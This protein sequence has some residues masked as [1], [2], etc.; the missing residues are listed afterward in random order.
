MYGL[1]LCKRSWD[2][3]ERHLERHMRGLE[4]LYVIL[5]T[6]EGPPSGFLFDTTALRRLVAEKFRVG[7]L[8]A[9]LNFLAPADSMISF[10]VTRDMMWFYAWGHDTIWDIS[11]VTWT[12]PEFCEA[13]KRGRERSWTR[14]TCALR[15]R[16]Y[17]YA[18]ECRDMVTSLIPQC[19]CSISLCLTPKVSTSSARKC[20][21]KFRATV[22]CHNHRGSSVN[23]NAHAYSQF[24]RTKFNYIIS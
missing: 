6:C 1:R 10:K 14:L 11:Y 13:E 9:E 8:S 4:W 2:V 15:L 20:L 17:W 23:S 22:L 24:V 18:R 21:E 7:T 16:E 12:W 19:T 3:P 5:L